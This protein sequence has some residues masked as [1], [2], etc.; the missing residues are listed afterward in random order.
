MG[1]N[2]AMTTRSPA[3]PSA[4]RSVVRA[5]KR[6]AYLL[7]GVALLPLVQTAQADCTPVPI[8]PA[9]Q[10]RAKTHLDLQVVPLAKRQA[11]LATVLG[12]PGK[13]LVGMGQIDAEKVLRMGVQ[14]DM[15]DMYFNGVG[16]RSWISWNLPIGSYVDTVA[17]SA[18]CLDAIPMF[19]VYQMAAR[20]DGNLSGLD[21]FGYMRDYWDNIRILFKRT[22]DLRRPVLI[23]LE[24]DFWGYAQR[25]NRS[26]HKLD[27]QVAVA[28]RGDC[29]G[30]PDNMKGYTACVLKM[31]RTLAPNAYVG[32]PPS[33]FYDLRQSEINYL[34]E[35][36]AHQADFVVMQTL[37]R[38][39]GCFEAAYA[40][41][42][43]NRAT[44]VRSMWTTADFK[45][46]FARARAHFEALGLP[47]IWWQT[48]L[49]VPS[50]QPGGKPGYFRDNR[51]AYFLSNPAELVAAGGVG[52]V[53]GSG[54]TAQTSFD[55]DGGQFKR[56]ATKYRQSPP[57]LP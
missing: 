41:A 56:L 51:V 50:D 44:D 48:P 39:I 12:K 17:N 8:S 2:A 54:E 43:C 38:D 25:R 5:L 30:L 47:I 29:A 20:G 42:N 37:D 26:P 1:K 35:A 55:T 16:P 46:H 23:N 4:L 21:D 53:F 6:H 33:L 34:L 11:A 7:L 31:A 9:I 57:V 18:A 27:V 3:L 49:G 24:P 40:P 15:Y 28:S 22:R 32:I 52:V 14:T 10:E 19:T 13:L 45:A 36:G